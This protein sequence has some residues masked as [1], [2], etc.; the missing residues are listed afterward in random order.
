MHN[1]V[2]TAPCV[3]V[4]VCRHDMFVCTVLTRVRF[5]LAL[6]LGGFGMRWYTVHEVVRGD[7]RE[8]EGTG[9]RE[10]GQEGGRGGKGREEWREVRGHSV[11]ST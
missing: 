5:L 11:D 3:H 7:R 8:G 10:R 4:H 1:S 9:G 2:N 6:E